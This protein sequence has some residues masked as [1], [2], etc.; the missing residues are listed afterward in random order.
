M[1]LA[2]T[3]MTAKDPL[4]SNGGCSVVLN[5]H[6]VQLHTPREKDENTAKNRDLQAE[7]EQLIPDGGFQRV[8]PRCEEQKLENSACCERPQ[9]PPSSKTDLHV[10]AECK[11]GI[12]S[13]GDAIMNEKARGRNEAAVEERPDDHLRRP[14]HSRET[15]E[16][17]ESDACSAVPDVGALATG[18]DGGIR[19]IRKQRHTEGERC[20]VYELPHIHYRGIVAVEL[21]RETLNENLI[22]PEWS[23]QK[24][25][26]SNSP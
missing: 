17:D 8:V 3:G 24:R 26:G 13:S 25:E 16:R 14:R 11:E 10:H 9:N 12:K 7:Y 6:L 21:A 2:L 20:E 1:M 15:K 4:S 23:D 22:E 19:S 5:D 18:G